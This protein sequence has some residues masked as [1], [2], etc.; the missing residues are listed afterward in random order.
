MG[1][2]DST[3]ISLFQCICV[4]HH[5]LGL[6]TDLSLLQ[7]F[8]KKDGLWMKLFV[9][10]VYV[11]DTAHQVMLVQFIFVYLVQEFGNFFFLLEIDRR[12]ILMKSYLRR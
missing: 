11:F 4:H 5:V 7:N 12:D 9:A 1:R 10:G 2:S 3:A 8:S 6:L